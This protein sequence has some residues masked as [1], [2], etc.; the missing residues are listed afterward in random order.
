MGYNPRIL[1]IFGAAIVVML[2]A[3]DSVVPF[4]GR[5]NDWGCDGWPNYGLIVN[6]KTAA[7]SSIRSISR[8]AAYLPF[9][10]I[11]YLFNM[12]KVEM[13]YFFGNIAVV[14]VTVFI[15]LR[16][17]VHPVAAAT[18]SI[19]TMLGTFTITYAST[20]YASTSA[21]T[22]GSI[23][24]LFASRAGFSSQWAKNILCLFCGSFLGAAFNAHP[25]SLIAFFT[26][27]LI[28]L[29]RD[30]E[31]SPFRE[32]LGAIVATLIGALIGTLFIELISTIVFGKFGITIIQL[33][34]V[35]ATVKSPNGYWSYAGWWKENGFPVFIVVLVACL[36]I[37]LFSYVRYR[38][39]HAAKSRMML[40]ASGSIPFLLAIA[41]T[42]ARGDY[43]LSYAGFL[44][45]FMLPLSLVM[46]ATFNEIIYGGFT[47]E[48][49]IS[50]ISFS[51][52]LLGVA[53]CLVGLLYGVW[54]VDLQVTWL[55]S[56][57]T[58]I[59]SFLILGYAM[60][61]KS[62]LAYVAGL[63]LLIIG[64]QETRAT[65]FAAPFWDYRGA[66]ASA[67][68]KDYRAIFHAVRFIGERVGGKYP[69]FWIDQ[70]ASTDLVMPIFRSFVRCGFNQSFPKELP[71][72]KLHWQHDLGPGEVLVVL[73]G[74]EDT[75]SQA[76]NTMNAAGLAFQKTAW[77][78]FVGA[79]ETVQVHL[80]IV[81][82]S[83]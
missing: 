49:L 53:L 13:L 58:A 4:L 62:K 17:F 8:I 33:D 83:Q 1:L 51:I 73:T 38:N 67:L 35:V 69:N 28:A 41:L 74:P 64:V 79:T 5:L 19:L 71:D 65:K 39:L 30:L 6:H 23:G 68:E 12:H 82:V 45:L 34:A 16:Y 31:G 80:G 42:L 52:Y 21:L 72:A 10:A 61:M 26:I 56:A 54:R 59:T 76:A 81:I 2:G 63:L 25:V 55:M 27:P 7:T 78:S 57:I 40:V 43:F 24:L 3:M 11:S 37:S 9:S 77:K 15:A 29:S 44:I 46:A 48:W 20:T 22:Y 32:A 66:S 47:N 75:M 18:A 14:S 60:V 36:V 70:N 50:P